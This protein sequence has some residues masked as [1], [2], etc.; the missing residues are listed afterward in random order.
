VMLLCLVFAVVLGL[1]TGLATA[2]L[3]SL[4]R[5]RAPMVPY[6]ATFLVVVRRREMRQ[7]QD[8]QSMG[9]QLSG[10]RPIGQGSS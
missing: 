7:R 5:Y 2:N 6:L 10:S 3:G 4:S 8:R 1:G 9:S